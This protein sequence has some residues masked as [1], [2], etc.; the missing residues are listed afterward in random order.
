MS[1]F[2]NCKKTNSEKEFYVI[3]AQDSIAKTRNLKIPP[4]P[5]NPYKW[6]SDVV[7]IFDSHNK[8]YIYQTEKEFHPDN[9]PKFSLD[10]EYP[11]FINLKP[12]HLITFESKDFINFIKNNDDIFGLKPNENNPFRFLYMASETDTIKNEALYD[13]TNL[14]SKPRSRIS[15]ILRRTT[16]EENIVLKYK[17]NLKEFAPENISWSKNFIN[18]KAAPF[19]KEYNDAE[20]KAWILRKAN[21]TFRKNSLE[22]PL[23]M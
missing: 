15:Y 13:F 7:F 19:T 11:N 2:V 3:S 14:I 20:S 12:E 22:V 6:Y 8:V 10:V 5:L 17:R 18:G 21:T 23:T 16:E 4:P 1:L 9:N